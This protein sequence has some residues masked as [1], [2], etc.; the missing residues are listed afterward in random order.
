MDSLYSGDFDGFCIVSSDSDFM[1][2]AI[3]IR[4]QNLPCYVFGGIKTQERFR[5]ACTRFVYLENLRYDVHDAASHAKM[6]P[7]R[8]MSDAMQMVRTFITSLAVEPGTWV[9]LDHLERELE[10]QTTDFDPRSYG[11]LRL[12]D[13]LVALRRPVIVDASR[14]GVAWVRLR[15]KSKRA[16]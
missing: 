5:R 4:E 7:L 10:R 14:D 6:K 12:R 11:H 15:V 3:R 1:R 9:Q 16:N 2:L 8:P 13:L